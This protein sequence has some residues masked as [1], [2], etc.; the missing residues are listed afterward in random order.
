M[1]IAEGYVQYSD[2]PVFFGNER[3][4]PQR[5]ALHSRGCRSLLWADGF[6]PVPFLSNL[7]RVDEWPL[8]MTNGR[9]Q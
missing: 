8:T 2:L 5:D 7:G 9:S 4:H 6:D 1:P 3:R